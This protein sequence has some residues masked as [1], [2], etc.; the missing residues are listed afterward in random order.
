M[1]FTNLTSSVGKFQFSDGLSNQDNRHSGMVAEKLDNNFLS[2]F[3]VVL[4]RDNLSASLASQSETLGRWRTCTIEPSLAD[5]R[6]IHLR[7][8]LAMLSPD[9]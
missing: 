6:T 5:R 3:V 1:L 8:M 2:K 7:S 9:T 4:S